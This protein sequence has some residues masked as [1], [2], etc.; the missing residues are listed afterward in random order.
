MEDEV[1]AGGSDIAQIFTELNRL[2]FVAPKAQI[3][4]LGRRLGWRYFA[5]GVGRRGSNHITHTLDSQLPQM[6]ACLFV[7]AGAAIPGVD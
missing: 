2:S 7:M 6:L 1:H 3:R 5:F 4:G